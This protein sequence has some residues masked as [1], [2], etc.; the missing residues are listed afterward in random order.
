[1]GVSERAFSCVAPGIEDIITR[2][3]EHQ[4]Q[5]VRY[6]RDYAYEALENAPS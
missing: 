6:E 1:M 5:G 3:D 2:N 4:R